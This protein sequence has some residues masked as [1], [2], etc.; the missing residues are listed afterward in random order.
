MV[1]VAV[2]AVGS[3]RLCISERGVRAE[4]V[5]QSPTLPRS[6]SP[7]A[8]PPNRFNRAFRFARLPINA[9]VY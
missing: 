9:F 2:V 3:L 7:P 8:H 6:A 4:S 1:L 5:P